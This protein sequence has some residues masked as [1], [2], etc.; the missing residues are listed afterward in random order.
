MLLPKLEAQL[1]YHKYLCNRL[2]LGYI[3]SSIFVGIGKGYMIPFSL[4][5]LAGAGL[6]LTWMVPVT[7]FFLVPHHSDSFC[8]FAKKFG[9]SLPFCNTIFLPFSS[10]LANCKWYIYFFEN[11]DNI[12]RL[13]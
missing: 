8:N 9:A 11:F 10:F 6:K 2:M 3:S 7:A 1:V 5:I 13:I 12:F 4:A